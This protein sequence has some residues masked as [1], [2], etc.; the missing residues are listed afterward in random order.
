MSAGKTAARPIR[1]AIMLACALAAA[2]L[3]LALFS[4]SFWD[5]AEL[6]FAGP[7]VNAYYFGNL[8]N[9]AI[10]LVLCGLG[11][12]ISFASRNFN[13]GGEGQIYIGAIVT[14]ATCLA[15]PEG[16]GLVP[17]AAAAAGS[18]AGALLGALSG[19]LKRALGVDE[20]ISSFLVSAAVVYLGD[21]LIAGPLRDGASNLQT[22]PAIPTAYRL[23]AIFPP[24]S[25]ST[26]CIVGLAA[27]LVLH[28]VVRRTR[29]GYELRIFGLN[30]DF[31][32]CVGIDAGAYAVAPMAISGAL[33]GLAGAMMILGTYH[34]AMKGFSAGI[35]WSG[36]AVALVAGNAPLAVLPAALLFA[37][38]EAGGKAVMIGADVGSEIVA[39]VQSVVFFLVTA[40]ALLDPFASRRRRGA[41]AAAGRLGTGAAR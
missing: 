13:L 28:F 27:V 17:L 11:A 15:F 37:Y 38:L 36:M 34:R 24:S 12:A 10:A 20:L 21:F 33:H 26:G 41:P 3:L 29:F 7:F 39:V 16:G 6:F 1:A 40:R 22:T 25:L 9:S 14:A 19:A 32:R 4:S 18:L 35:G 2:L 5:A 30:R 23:S 8:L 31:A